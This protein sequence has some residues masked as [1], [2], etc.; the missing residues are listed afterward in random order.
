[1]DTCILQPRQIDEY[2]DQLEC[3]G[4]E[5]ILTSRWIACGCGLVRLAVEAAVE[6]GRGG[7]ER[8]HTAITTRGKSVGVVWQLLA[9]ETW[10]CHLL[11]L[12]LPPPPPP[13]GD[14]D[15]KQKTDDGLITSLPF[16]MVLQVE[17]AAIGV[18]ESIAFHEDSVVELDGLLLDVVDYSVRQLVPLV[19]HTCTDSS[20]TSPH[21]MYNIGAAHGGSQNIQVEES[22]LQ[23]REE[24]LREK[25]RLALVLG[26]RAVGVLHLLASCHKQLP[27]CVVTRLMATHDVPQLLAKV[28]E[29]SPWQKQEN[30]HQY[31]FEEGEWRQVGK[32]TPPLSRSECQ[33]WVALA[34][35][36]LDPEARS[37]YEVS[38][39]RRATLLRLQPR[40]QQAALIQVPALEPLARW[41]ATLAISPPQP[42]RPQPLVT[43][44]AQIGDGVA[45]TWAGRWEELAGMMRER[46]LHPEPSALQGLASNMATAWDLDALELLLPDSPVCAACGSP[47]GRRCS[48]CRSQWYCRRLV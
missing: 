4:M 39:G 47:A 35:L 21:A 11:P 7:Q 25:M 45:G 38:S 2:V 9:C 8:V 40:L 26:C 32:N 12:L 43:A 30:G 16:I 37:G 33:A 17:A 23:A 42:V 34:T 18:L 5:E 10:R 22:G 46:F 28:L 29:T 20:P 31:A 41:L 14:E 13:A 36:L 24:V 3:I 19:A 27:L 48:R 15:T 44:L 1:M 6:A